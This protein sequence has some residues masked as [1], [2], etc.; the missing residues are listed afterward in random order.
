MFGKDEIGER[1]FQMVA[2]DT[3]N[4]TH[5]VRQVFQTVLE[6]KDLRRIV[7]HQADARVG[8]E[9]FDLGQL[10]LQ[11][12]HDLLLVQALKQYDLIDLIDQVSAEQ[13]VYL[14]QRQEVLARSFDLR[15]ILSEKADRAAN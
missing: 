1:E 14:F 5:A 9:F 10:L 15:L 4:L 2:D 13:V 12:G 3:P 6:Q 7:K 8:Q 11:E